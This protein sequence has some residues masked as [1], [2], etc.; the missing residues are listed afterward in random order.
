MKKQIPFR[1][2]D[3]DLKKDFEALFSLRYNDKINK[4]LTDAV[5]IAGAF[6]RKNNSNPK[7]ETSYYE[8]QEKIQKTLDIKLPY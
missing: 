6:I 4:A 7:A 2:D 1:Y 8:I 3:E 5:K